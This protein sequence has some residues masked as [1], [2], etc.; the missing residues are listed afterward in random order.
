MN[1]TPPSPQANL[2]SVPT[3][4]D[5]VSHP[6]QAKD[7][8]VHVA[9]DLLAQVASLQPLLLGRLYTGMSLG[10]KLHYD[11]D[12][13]L[14]VGEAADLLGMSEDYLYRHAHRFP[15]TVRPAPRQ[16]RFSKSGIQ[17]Y[18]QQRQGR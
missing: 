8:P 14:A 4:N 17:R 15:F 12:R 5:L 1:M 16:V 10:A 2:A 3:L 13:L 6:E 9:A 18:I 11:E 7:L